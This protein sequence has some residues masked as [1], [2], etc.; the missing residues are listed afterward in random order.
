MHKIIKK[1]EDLR[2]AIVA[3]IF[4]RMGPFRS[5]KVR[6]GTKLHFTKP[7]DWADEIYHYTV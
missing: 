5:Q 3:N 1:K 4:V 2:V 6:M 7:V